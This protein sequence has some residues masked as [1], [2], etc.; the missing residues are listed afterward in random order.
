MLPPPAYP[1]WPSAAANLGTPAK[2]H[3]LS[4]LLCDR[5][6]GVATTGFSGVSRDELTQLATQQKQ[7]LAAQQRQ[8]SVYQVTGTV[9]VLVIEQPLIARQ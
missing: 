3:L 9:D 6:D 7:Q 8:F 4:A 2:S 1:V 5:S